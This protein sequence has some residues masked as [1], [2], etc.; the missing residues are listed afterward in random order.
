MV[1]LGPITRLTPAKPKPATGY[2]PDRDL[3][4]TKRLPDQPPAFVERRKGDRRSR[5][6]STQFDSRSGTD[7]RRS[8]KHRVD[9]EV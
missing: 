9:I 8:H 1:Y 7:R 2:E 5:D 4:I 6:R 3:L